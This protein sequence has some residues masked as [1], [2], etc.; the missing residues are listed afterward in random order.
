MAATP[1]ALL[2]DRQQA[3]VLAALAAIETADTP[4]PA[5]GFRALIDPALRATVQDCL[6]RAGRTLIDAGDG[7]LSGYDDRIGARLAADGLGVL[8]RQDAAVLT[9]VLL[10]SVAIP[11]A[12][13]DLGS[14]DWRDGQPVT[15]EQLAKSR[16]PKKVINASVQ[17]LRDA[18]ILRYAGRRWLAPGPQFDRLTPAASDAIWE[19][20]ILA[21]APH[22]MEA[23]TIRRRRERRAHD[24][25]IT[26]VTA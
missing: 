20:L 25:G 12:R 10:H 14:K 2:S 26:G 8:S 18:G 15:K 13:G 19:G 23:E 5:I 16:L 9:L 17:R 4:V 3:D 11:R 24:L 21:A 7:Y 22:G 6:N 1:L